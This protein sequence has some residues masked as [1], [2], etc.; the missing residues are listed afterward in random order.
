M[1]RMPAG[2]KAVGKRLWESVN[3]EFVFNND[4]DKV[5]L[6][7]QACRVTEK[8]AELDRASNTEPLVVKSSA[9]QKVINPLISEVRFQRGLLAQLL[10]KLNLPGTD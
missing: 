8:I 6:L 4:P 1:P 3:A 10:G 2:F 9:G 5:E 7:V